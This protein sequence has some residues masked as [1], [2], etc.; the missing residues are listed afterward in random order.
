MMDSFIKL[1][2]QGE[3]DKGVLLEYLGTLPHSVLDL[4][5][6]GSLHAVHQHHV[7]VPVDG[8]H[9]SPLRVPAGEQA[10]AQPLTH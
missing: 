9:V 4:L 1:F 6:D 8:L 5:D 10:P 3:A 2:T 7:P